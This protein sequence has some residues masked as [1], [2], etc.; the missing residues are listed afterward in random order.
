VICITSEINKK[1]HDKIQVRRIGKRNILSILFLGTAGQIAWSVENS[2]FNTFVFDRITTD[3]TPVA[4]MVAVSAITATITTIF[5]GILSDRTSGKWGK[6]KPFIVFGYILWGLI[7]AIYP[8]VEWIQ[9]IGVAILIVIMTDAVMTF[10]GSMA[11]DAAYNAW[12]TDI[13]HSSNR[14]RIQSINSITI[15]VAAI[16]SLVAAGVIIDIFGYFVFFYIL[17]G[18]VTITGVIATFLIESTPIEKDRLKIEKS[19]LKEFADIMNPRILKENRILFL[20]FLSMALGSI[21]SQVYM[22]YLFIYMEH[23][24]GF[25]KTE[26]S[27]FGALFL[28]L[29]VVILIIAG[30]YS[31]R[32]NR[33]TLVVIGSILGALLT[34]LLGFTSFL[35][36]GNS[37]LRIMSFLL[38]FLATIPSLASSVAFGGWIFDNYPEGDVGKFQ[39]IRM[40][41][42]V[43]IPMVLGPP[44]G[45]VIISTF[46]IPIAEGYIPTPEIFIFGGLISLLSVI[47]IFFISKSEGR[48][49]LE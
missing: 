3:P 4:W 9:M 26:L 48:I 16:T 39:G 34:I 12:L 32:I 47:P 8:M 46:G 6:R 19:F 30:I 21:G 49:N 11:N 18:V 31:H 5:M 38:Y 2:W 33:K 37:S 25:S 22:P 13:G 23:Y 24:I 29:T 27:I 1:K 43:L 42:A 40:I 28:L 35:T 20:L 36:Q 45:S 15:Y 44:I 41:F 10:F 17:G 14:N 7:T